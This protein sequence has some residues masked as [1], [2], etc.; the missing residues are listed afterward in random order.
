MARPRL[1]VKC[2]LPGLPLK[3]IPYGRGEVGAMPIRVLGWEDFLSG[4][5]WR[6]TDSGVLYR[7]QGDPSWGLL[8]SIFRNDHGVGLAMPIRKRRLTHMS[9]QLIAPFIQLWNR[10]NLAQ[11]LPDD[12]FGRLAIAQHYGIPTPALDWTDNPL[13]A[14]FMAVQFQ[15]P[16]SKAVRIF[17]LYRDHLPD[18]IKVLTPYASPDPRLRAQLAYLTFVMDK[19]VGAQFSIEALA[20]ME[21][22]TARKRA[23]NYLDW[24]TVRIS[25][26]ERRQALA[27]FK[28]YRLSIDELFPGSMHW[29]IQQIRQEFVFATR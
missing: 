15:N 28:N 20:D 6:A 26:Q 22:G 11:K 13:M 16:G 14:L 5:F 12:L 1:Y 18:Y 4:P 24:I 3:S 7:G 9:E 19:R 2:I 27:E 25:D 8:P 23:L 17:R 10:Q 21:S 29:G